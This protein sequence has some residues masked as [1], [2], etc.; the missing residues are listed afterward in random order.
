MEKRKKS[1]VVQALVLEAWAKSA[2]SR[3]D[4]ARVVETISP[5]HLNRYLAGKTD[6]YMRERTIEAVLAALAEGPQGPKREA[7]T[8]HE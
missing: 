1:R 8:R 5:S 6:V 7:M 2:M 4:L 3:M